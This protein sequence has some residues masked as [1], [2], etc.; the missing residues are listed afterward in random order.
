MK[1][2]ITLLLVLPLSA[3]SMSL[4]NKLKTS[5]GLNE[6]LKTVLETYHADEQKI[7]SA[8]KELIYEVTA[9]SAI[10]NLK[11]CF[12]RGSKINASKIRENIITCSDLYRSYIIYI[13]NLTKKERFDVDCSKILIEMLEEAISH[14]V[15][16]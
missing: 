3:F 5:E 12:I 1:I 11:S 14:G 6:I 9:N 15:K 13:E 8:E 10:T 2:L 16:D 4:E 7:D